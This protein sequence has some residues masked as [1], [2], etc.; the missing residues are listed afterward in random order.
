MTSCG[1]QLVSA[2]TIHKIVFAILKITLW[3]LELLYLIRQR[4]DKRFVIHDVIWSK[5][6]VN[7][8]VSALHSC[9]KS[10]RSSGK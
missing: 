3:E 8:N 5:Y 2:L 6:F 1:V 10:W 9:Q 7:S 4:L